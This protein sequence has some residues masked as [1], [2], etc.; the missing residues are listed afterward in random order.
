MED[1]ISVIVPIYNTGIYL[2]KCVESI[3]HQDYGC[4]EI[5]LVNDGSTDEETIKLCC[6]IENEYTFVRVIHKE[7]GGS[8]SAR[9]VGIANARGNYIVFIDSD[10]YIEP[11]MFSTLLKNAKEQNVKLVIGGMVIDGH[12]K[13]LRPD[14]LP[15]SMKLNTE[16]ALHYF[17]LGHWHSA[18]T[19]LYHRSIFDELRFPENETNEDYYFNFNVISMLESIY[20]NLE[21][22][23]HYVKRE[24]SNTTSRASIK[25]LDWISHTKTIYSTVME[26]EH[27]STLRKEAE[28][29]YL[30]SN[31]VLA[32]KALL[33]LKYGQSKEAD[34]IYQIASDNLKKCKHK[35]RTNPYLSGKY[36]MMGLMVACM[37]MAYR[38]G[39]IK[40]LRVVSKE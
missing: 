11:N 33:T 13:I 36:R 19:N 9:N 24:D 10:D 16:L 30:F 17:M 34:E 14:S 8:S 12:K 20:V 5:I 39:V 40:G 28:Y 21:I 6:K 22:F 32:N 31:I 18:C 2:M 4:F 7:N 23:Y 25:H 26:D 38:W 15:K 1:M 3:V 29:Q 27:L 35:L 37:P